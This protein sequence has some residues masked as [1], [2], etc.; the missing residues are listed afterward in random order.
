MKHSG[1]E[2]AA[3]V[4]E[5]VRGDREA[6]KRDIVHHLVHH[7]GKDPIYSTTR[8]WLTATSL[9][10]RDRLIER[11]LF[12]KRHYAQLDVKR[13]YYLSM[14][15]LLGRMLGSA[16]CNMGMYDECVAA[17]REL[18]VDLDDIEDME[19]DAALGNGGLGR[20]AA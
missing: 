9:A 4:F 18:D 10:V 3:A 7:V 1:A 2:A 13:V 16:L 19:P 6:L 17:L 8:D 14:E 5:P 20:L 15:F 11:R 12:T